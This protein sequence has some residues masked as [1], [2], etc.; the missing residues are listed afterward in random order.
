MANEQKKNADGTPKATR[1]KNT[2]KPK[3]WTGAE[4]PKV[5]ILTRNVKSV[6]GP[7]KVPIAY[8]EYKL[9]GVT[10]PQEA[11]TLFKLKSARAVAAIVKGYNALVRQAAS[12]DE[13]LIRKIAERKGISMEE[14]RK[15]YE[16]IA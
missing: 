15:R 1:A 7:T 16:A 9:R 4:D 10:D 5:K 8:V 11:L 6:Y 13:P 12:G 2:T 3:E 14:A